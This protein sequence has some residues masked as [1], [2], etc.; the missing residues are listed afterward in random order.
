MDQDKVS[1]LL[2]VPADKVEAPATKEAMQSV[3][4]QS[5]PASLIE[6]LQV[7]YIPE[8]P[9]GRTAALNAARDQAKGE[10]LVH[11]EPGVTWDP[12][13]IER[14]VLRLREGSDDAGVGSAHRMSVRD[15][16]GKL[17]QT[18][19]D[20]LRV[21]GLRIATLLA[22]PW[23]PGALLIKSEVMDV[24]GAYRHIKEQVWEH[25]IR[26]A[27]KGLVIELLDDDLAVW[28]VEI[29]PSANLQRALFPS[30]TRAS[31]LKQHLD[32]VELASL[33]PTDSEE[34]VILLA[35]LHLFNDDLETSHEICQGFGR[36]NVPANYWHG[37]LHRREPDFQNSKGWF[38]RAERWEGLLQIRDSVQDVLQRVLLMPEYG[39]ARDK[40]FELKRHIDAGGIWDP[41][42]FVDM[43]ESYQASEEKEEAEALLLREIQEAEMVA[44]LDWTYRCAVA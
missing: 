11:T 35:G 24:L 22:P 7:Q 6:T 2:V 44:A 16:S 17:K 10:F 9:G 5:Y 3:A 34:R 27:E 15:S 32:R 18:S 12:S 30:G 40:A 4:S 1:V 25:D 42:Y 26:L 33:V 38:G 43:C 29:D 41:V 13:K 8:T 14:Q 37:L 20:L 31:F 39:H 23:K 36:E 19:F 28:N 21:L